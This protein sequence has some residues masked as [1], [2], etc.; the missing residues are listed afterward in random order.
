MDPITLIV[1]AVATG[2]A[3]G[4]GDVVKQAIT[5]A[6][7]ALKRRISNDYGVVDAEV[8]SVESEPEEDLRRQ[9]LAKQLTKV[10]AG[11][12]EQLVAAAQE[13][14]NLVIDEAPQAAQIVGIELN[15]VDVGGDIEV[16]DVAVQGGSGVT[17]TDV[18][19]GGSFT[20]SN[21]RASA[22]EPPHPPQAR[23]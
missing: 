11:E 12:D 19:T 6:Y 1:A 3:A 7:A 4:T 20:I 16:I 23:R 18:S 17:A 15:R 5:D 14:L 13:L 2:A 21:V 9:L 8:L 10:G 22:G